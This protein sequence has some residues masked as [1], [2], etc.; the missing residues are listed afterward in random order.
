MKKEIEDQFEAVFGAHAKKV[1]EQRQAKV[2]RESRAEGFVRTFK[3]HCARSLR[4]VLEQVG[5]YLSTKGMETRIEETDEGAAADGK[6]HTALTLRL[7]MGA[8]ER[9]YRAHEQPHLSLICD[10]HRQLVTLHQCTMRPGS[11]GMIGP[12]GMSGPVGEFKL[13]QLTEELL[14]QKALALVRE[15]LK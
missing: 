2:A 10:K 7:L 11:G 4:P 6:Q 12:V 9:H 13:E 3:E 5:Q 1:E 14:Q 8:E 15:V